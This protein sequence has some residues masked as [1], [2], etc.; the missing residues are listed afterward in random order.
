LAGPGCG[1]VVEHFIRELHLF[2]LLGL[3]PIQASRAS[4]GGPDW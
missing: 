1:R 4:L 3:S 2:A